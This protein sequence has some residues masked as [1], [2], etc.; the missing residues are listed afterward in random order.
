MTSIYL[1]KIKKIKNDLVHLVYPSICTIC[2]NELPSHQNFI[3]SFCK[4]EFQFTYFER[5]SEPTP[6]DQLFWGRVKVE[7]TYSYLYF[8]KGKS[9]QPVLHALKY[10]DKP[11]VGVEM[12]K[13]IGENVKN[14]ASFQSIDALVPV[15]IHPKKEFIRGYNQSE[16]LAD[17]ISE[18]LNV[19]VVVDFLE[20]TK[21]S[22]SQTKKNRFLRWDNVEN[23]FKSKN[24]SHYKHIAIVD[25]VI[26]TGATL[27]VII[28]T[29]Q[30]NNPEIRISVISLA[31]TK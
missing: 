9:A 1:Q 25:D 28:R 31:L 22:E 17:G 3:C 18:V 10:K 4:T 7:S 26:T 24:R 13:I 21:F 11:E 12:G 19:P 6:L 30:E 16:K 23:N 5:F 2:E 8:E 20:R 15:P 29:I 27:E 14:I